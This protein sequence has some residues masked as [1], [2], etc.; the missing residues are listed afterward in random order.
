MNNT[1][2]KT[3]Q[4]GQTLKARSICDSGC[5]FEVA[6]LERKGSFVRV[7]AQSI[8]RRVKVFTDNRGEYVFALGR[9]SMAPLFRP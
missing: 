4:A 8:E 3:I 6:V 2:P 7:K 1:L 5:V 9:Y